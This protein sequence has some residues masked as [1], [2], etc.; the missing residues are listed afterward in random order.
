MSKFKVG[1]HVTAD[2]DA[3]PCSGVVV[4][5]DLYQDLFVLIKRDDNG[6]WEYDGKS[7]GIPKSRTDLIGVENLW[8]IKE[9]YLSISVA[10]EDYETDE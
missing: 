4:I 9:A 10:P 3:D 8:W 1:D 5:P 6:G 2:C 7:T